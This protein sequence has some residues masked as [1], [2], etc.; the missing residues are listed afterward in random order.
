V[1][2]KVRETNECNVIASLS[3]MAR[4]IS[5]SGGQEDRLTGFQC[6]NGFLYLSI[7]KHNSPSSHFV[8]HQNA[9]QIDVVQSENPSQQPL[10]A[11]KLESRNAR[12]FCHAWDT[13]TVGI[14]SPP[15]SYAYGK[16][17]S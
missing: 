4:I 16:H 10:P 6:L 8:S 3:R 2:G 17:P 7:I 14:W 5:S 9:V 11:T 12:D 13:S 15:R 1:K